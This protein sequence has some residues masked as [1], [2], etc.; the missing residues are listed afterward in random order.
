MSKS[1]NRSASAKGVSKHRITNVVPGLETAIFSAVA[2]AAVKEGGVPLLRQAYEALRGRES[3]L[4]QIQAAHWAGVE[5]YEISI[6]IA[7]LTIHALYIENISVEKPT[8]SA[9][10]VLIPGKSG[11]GYDAEASHDKWVDM[12]VYGPIIL[13]PGGDPP[14]VMLRVFD[15]ALPGKAGTSSLLSRGTVDL[16]FEFTRLDQP[17]TEDKYLT[18]RVR[19]KT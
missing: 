9:L 16:K 10:K 1:A 7:N 8:D 5:E 18:V 4:L 15:S 13:A 6:A 19:P 12:G 3:L 11:F 17:K 2:G 14:S